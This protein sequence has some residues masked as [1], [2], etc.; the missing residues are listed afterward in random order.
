[1]SNIDFLN[2]LIPMVEQC[3]TVDEVLF[4]LNK[5]QPLLQNACDKEDAE[6]RES[7]AH[8][9]RETYDRGAS[10]AEHNS[11]IM[12]ERLVRELTDTYME[13]YKEA[14]KTMPLF[15]IIL[16]RILNFFGVHNVWNRLP[17]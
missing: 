10:T 16:A 1:M 5:M 7:L 6:R 15:V 11:K 14:A 9:L 8:L 12:E 13:D 17:R 2:S 3:K 4:G